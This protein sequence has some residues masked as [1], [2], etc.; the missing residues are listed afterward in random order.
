VRPYPSPSRCLPVAPSSGGRQVRTAW[1]RD[2][3]VAQRDKLVPERNDLSAQ[4]DKLVEKRNDLSALRNKLVEKRDDLSAPRK[5]L[6]IPRFSPARAVRP[7]AS[8]APSLLCSFATRFQ[9]RR[10]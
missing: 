10:C 4:R 7:R 3:L 2:D 9:T 5:K 6:E 1:C 8:S